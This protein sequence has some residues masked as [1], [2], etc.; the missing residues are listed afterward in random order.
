MDPILVISAVGVA[1]CL[2]FLIGGKLK[3]FRWAGG[4]FVR[5]IVGALAL[6]FLNTFGSAVGYHLPINFFTVGVAGIL[7]LPGL[8]MLIAADLFI[9]G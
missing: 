4:I 2:L 7:G 8:V 9:I 5:V 3:L 1:A 6:F